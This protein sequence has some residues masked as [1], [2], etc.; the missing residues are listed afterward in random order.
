MYLDKYKK[1]EY[2]YYIK[3]NERGFFIMKKSIVK[4][5]ALAL[6]AVM[7]CAVLASCSAPASNPDDAEKALK[8]NGYTVVRV[9]NS[10][11]GAIGLAV[12]TAVGIEGIETVITAT[13][14]DEAITVFYFADADAANAEWEDVQKWSEDE[15]DEDSDW[16]LKK[17]GKMI[18]AGT[19]EAIKAAK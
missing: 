14:G 16:V 7:M 10:G 4:V 17:S 1:A 12:F 11:F 13:N 9:D 18:Y 8:D 19:K 6:V 3:F 2:N 15:Q 5:L